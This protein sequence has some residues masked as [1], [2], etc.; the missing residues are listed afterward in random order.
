MNEDVEAWAGRVFV[1]LQGSSLQ[2]A[3]INFQVRGTGR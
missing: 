3:G 1:S 2:A